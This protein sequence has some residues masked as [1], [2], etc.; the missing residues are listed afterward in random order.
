MEGYTIKPSTPPLPELICD[1]SVYVFEL[2]VAAAVIAFLVSAYYFL[3]SGGNSVRLLQGRKVLYY[4]AM[5]TV[6]LILS[7]GATA[8]V[9]DL[10]GVTATFQG[11]VSA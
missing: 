6:V 10:V 3:T 5:G 7:W 11:C 1:I 4:A 9:A 2:A 8:I